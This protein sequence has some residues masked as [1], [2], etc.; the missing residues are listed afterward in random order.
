MVVHVLVAAGNA[1]DPLP[2]QGP[3][4]VYNCVRLAS[5]VKAC[6]HPID[7]PDRPVRFPQQQRASVR[8]D[9]AALE[10][11]HHPLAP[12]PFEFELLRDTLCWHRTP[13]RNLVS[14]FRTTTF[15]DSWGRCTYSG[16]ISGLRSL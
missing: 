6:R 12:K 10:S 8:G 13:P 5:V 3:H 4:R 2:D 14:L 11:R 7:E 9:G 16:E 1:D 15:S